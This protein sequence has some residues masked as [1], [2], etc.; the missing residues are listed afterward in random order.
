LPFHLGIHTTLTSDAFADD[1]GMNECYPSIN[2]RLKNKL[3]P[4]IS[5]FGHND[6]YCPT[7]RHLSRFD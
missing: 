4:N 3:R 5:S 1:I 7:K 2:S 6:I